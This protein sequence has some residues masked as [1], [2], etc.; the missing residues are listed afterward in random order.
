MKSW[1]DGLRN[2][3]LCAWECGVDRT[4]NNHG[5]C[6]IGLPEIAY[7]NITNATKSV[8]V[9]FLGCCFRCIYCNAYRLS[10]YPSVGWMYRGYIP[11]EDLAEELWSNLC[12]SKSKEV[13]ANAVNF[14][15]GEPTINL[16]YIKRVVDIMRE[17]N[18]ELR[19]GFATNGFASRESFERVIDVST[20]INFEIKAYDDEIHRAVTGAPVE[21][22]LKNAELLMKKA[23]TKI[24]VIRTVVIPEINDR[25]VENIAEFIASIDPTVSYRIVGFRPNFLLYYHPGPTEKMMENLTRKAK[26]KGLQDV[27]WSGYYPKA[28]SPLIR[29]KTNGNVNKISRSA[30]NAY[31][32]LSLSGCSAVQR[33]CGKCPYR[34][35]CPSML[36]EP[37]DMQYKI[38]NEAN[39]NDDGPDE[40]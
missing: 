18:N 11:P 35:N 17:G 6:R 39:N 5:V 9:T 7:T 32:Y 21:P 33:N 34:Q 15:G 38:R 1:V 27:S 10:Q 22:V 13:G 40:I 16:P 23:R 14:T 25:D 8:T 31:S 3:K 19:V 4:N 36:M 2:C 28:I 12:S 29:R 30:K 26:A 37:W 20:W 24:R